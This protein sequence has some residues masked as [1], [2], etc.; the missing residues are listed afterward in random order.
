[1]TGG[2]SSKLKGST[3]ERELALALG[4]KRT[5]LSGASGGG[6]I[7]LQPDNVWHAWSWEAKRRATLPKMITDALAQAEHDVAIGDQRR[8]A[9]AMREDHGRTIAV[10]YLE[11]LTR[12]IEAITEL[13]PSNSPTQPTDKETR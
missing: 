6:D 12:W 11:D 10:F 7:T 2:R 1:V 5:P 9:L 13:G 3:F 4:G 8:P